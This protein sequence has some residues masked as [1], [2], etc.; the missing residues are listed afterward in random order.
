VHAAHSSN[1]DAY[2]VLRESQSAL[3]D[4]FQNLLHPNRKMLALSAISKAPIYHE[5]PAC[6]SFQDGARAWIDAN[7]IAAHITGLAPQA[8]APHTRAL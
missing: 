4:R 7:N 3:R 2:Q 6:V 8:V 1:N 5:H